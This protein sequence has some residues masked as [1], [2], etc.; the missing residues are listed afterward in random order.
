[1]AA[2]IGRDRRMDAPMFKR[3]LNGADQLVLRNSAVPAR[4]PAVFLAA[5]LRVA[6]CGG[7]FSGAGSLGTGLRFAFGAGASG[8]RLILRNNSAPPPMANS[9]GHST[10]PATPSAP[11]AKAAAGVE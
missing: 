6:F 10:R 5:G 2:R 8:L 4:R 3:L 1:M 9:T 7:G 11:K